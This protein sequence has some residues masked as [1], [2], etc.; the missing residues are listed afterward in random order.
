[1]STEPIFADH[2]RPGWYKM[3]YD[4]NG[5][6]LPV[7]IW[8]QDGELVARVGAERAEPSKIWT[9]CADK[10][11]SKEAAKFAFAKGFWPDEPPPIGDN[12]PPV[13]DPYEA[14]KAEIEAK[15]KQATDWIGARPVVLTQPDADYATNAQREL[16]ALNKR[17]DAMFVAEKAPHLEAGRVVDERYRFRGAVADVAARLRK[18]FDR[19]LA[20]EEKRQTVAA[21]AKHKAEVAR[22]EAERKRLEAERAEKLRVDPIA[23]LTEDPPELP[24]VPAAPEAVKV[25]A[26]G[27]IGRRAGLQDVW[28]G[29]ITDYGAAAAYFINHPKMVELVD[30]LVAHQVKDLKAS[31]SIPG[32]TVSKERRAA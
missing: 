19:F 6:W 2:P 14:L 10:P 9:W 31:A 32:V 5:K 29:T 11:V 22:I 28:V 27:G 24:L 18:I 4:R 1:M 20:E 7:A 13:D 16:L 26:G 21:A 15:Q 23:A 12:M 8:I 30:K 25:A 3:R 17:A